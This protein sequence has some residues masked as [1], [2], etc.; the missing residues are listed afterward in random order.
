MDITSG[1]TSGIASGVNGTVTADHTRGGGSHDGRC[2]A[3]ASSLKP[4]LALLLLLLLVRRHEL[5]VAKE[6]QAIHA[7]PHGIGSLAAQQRITRL[8]TDRE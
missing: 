7:R 3:T 5:D 4:P 8:A 1:I 2:L 6:E